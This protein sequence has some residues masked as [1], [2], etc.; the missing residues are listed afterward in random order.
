MLLTLFFSHI[1]A[2]II[3]FGLLI[4][5]YTSTGYLPG[6]PLSTEE[7]HIYYW[8]IGKRIL[9]SIRVDKRQQKR[10]PWWLSKIPFPLGFKPIHPPLNWTEVVPANRSNET[11][12]ATDEKKFKNPRPVDPKATMIFAERDERVPSYLIWEPVNYLIDVKTKETLSYNFDFT[13]IYEIID[14]MGPIGRPDFKM[15]GQIDLQSKIGPWA[16]QKGVEEI[17]ILDIDDIKKDICFE[18]NVHMKEYLDAKVKPFGCVVHTIALNKI[19]GADTNEYYDRKKE[20][21]D[22]VQEALNQQAQEN[23]RVQERI[24]EINDAKAV[25]EMNVIEIDS[26]FDPVTKV[27]ATIYEGEAKVKAARAN[28]LV[29]AN[30]ETKTIGATILEKMFESAEKVAGKDVFRARKREE[31]EH[32]K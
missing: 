14:D 8:G 11:I 25:A 19:A 13:V 30:H 18:G 16:A 12:G 20:E 6:R 17:R 31:A 26:F 5:A 32:A 22:L 10:L 9:G 4:A 1:V 7:G 23:V 2:G 24:T 21:Q 28:M 29:E 27:A 3:D 15:I